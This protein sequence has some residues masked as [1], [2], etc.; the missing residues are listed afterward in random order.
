M[1]IEEVVIVMRAS[2]FDEV[3]VPSPQCLHCKWLDE[4]GLRCPAFGDVPI[5]EEIQLNLHDH[6]YA[7]DGDGG[8]RFT[9]HL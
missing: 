8:I 4:M 9:A 6:Q 1:L 7:F 2:S 3:R 5:P